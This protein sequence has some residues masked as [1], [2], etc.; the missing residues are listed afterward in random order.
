MTDVR[1]LT[2]F[3]G[4]HSVSK[5]LAELKVSTWLRTV[6][7]SALSKTTKKLDGEKWTAR[8]PTVSAVFSQMDHGDSAEDDAE[9]TLFSQ[10]FFSADFSDSLLAMLQEVPDRRSRESQLDPDLQR[11]L[12]QCPRRVC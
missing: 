3:S 6:S 5:A 11:L 12:G 4:T 7:L 1:C 9:W 10:H 8:T 2:L